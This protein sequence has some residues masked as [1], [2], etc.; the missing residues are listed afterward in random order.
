[1]PREP[2][3]RAASRGRA[4]GPR[5]LRP[6]RARSAHANQAAVRGSRPERGARGMRL[7]IG[8]RGSDLALWQARHVASRL[9]GA[10]EI[11]ITVLQT[12]GDLIDDVPLTGVE[13]RAFFTGEI[14]RA[15]LA[16]EID[17]AVHSHK[18]LP[19]ELAP[20]LAIA[21]IPARASPLERL[22]ALPE[23]HDPAAG[24]L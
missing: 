21:A 16:G 10:A 15:L 17:V 14:E 5:R 12:R 24:F 8:T 7:R 4:L 22:L 9:Q 1:P 20:G 2:Q 13:G 19:T 11:E 6:H 3:R 23:A 18:D